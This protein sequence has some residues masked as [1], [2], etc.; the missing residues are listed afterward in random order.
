MASV[1]SYDGV[2]EIDGNKILL[3]ESKTELLFD[4]GRALANQFYI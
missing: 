1:T 4:F 3:K 2:S